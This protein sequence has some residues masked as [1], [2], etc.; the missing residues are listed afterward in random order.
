VIAKYLLCPWPSHAENR[1][2]SSPLDT[3][4]E[5]YT[6]MPFNVASKVPHKVKIKDTH[7]V[8]L[9][10]QK[11]S[12]LAAHSVAQNN[13]PLPHECIL[14]IPKQNAKSKP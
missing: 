3:F 12:C 9:L 11:M 4:E 10:N 2:H 5:E 1:Y 14:P 7:M 13:I 6:L 8:A